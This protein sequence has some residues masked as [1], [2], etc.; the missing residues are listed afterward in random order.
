[1]HARTHFFDPDSLLH[2]AGL[3]TKHRKKKSFLAPKKLW[4]NDSSAILQL[5]T[6]SNQCFATTE[7]IRYSRHCEYL[8]WE[9]LTDWG[10]WGH[11]KCAL[12]EH[13]NRHGVRCRWKLHTSTMKLHT[14]TMLITDSTR[15]D[16]IL[17]N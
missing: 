17:F 14:S 2:C 7:W 15:Y 6:G 4:H 13:K 11:G 16:I 8:M 9:P 10:G 5:S 1:M 3:S 12:F